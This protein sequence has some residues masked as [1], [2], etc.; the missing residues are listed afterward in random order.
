VIRRHRRGDDAPFSRLADR[1][2]TAAPRTSGGG[3]SSVG[4]NVF[5]NTFEH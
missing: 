3:G 5:A 1:I 2:L 4:E